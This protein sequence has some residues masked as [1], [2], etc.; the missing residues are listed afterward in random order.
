[1]ISR[2]HG[3]KPF[4]TSRSQIEMLKT[5]IFYQRALVDEGGVADGI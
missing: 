4:P 1:M 2:K 3:A 5:A